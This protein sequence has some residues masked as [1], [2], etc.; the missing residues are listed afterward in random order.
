MSAM[1]REQGTCTGRGFADTDADGWCAK[2]KTWVQKPIASGG[3]GWHIILDKSAQPVEVAITAVDTGSNTITAP[4]HGLITG[5][6][7]QFFTTGTQMGGVTT[8]TT[9][10]ALVLSGDTLQVQNSLM[11]SAAIRTITSAGSNNTIRRAGP[12]IVVCE[13]ATPDLQDNKRVI[14]VGYRI[15]N[16]ALVDIQHFLSAGQY[17]T[18]GHPSGLWSGRTLKAVDAGPFTYDFRGGPEFLSLQTKVPGDAT[19]YSDTIDE[20]APLDGLCEDDSVVGGVVVGDV[21]YTAGNQSTPLVVTLQSAAQVDSFTVRQGYFIYRVN[22]SALNRSP[23][24]VAYGIINGK[25]VDDGLTAEQIRFSFVSG[26]NWSV[27]YIGNGARI[28]PYYHN[29]CCFGTRNASSAGDFMGSFNDFNG[30]S[31]GTDGGDAH[32][33]AIAKGKLPYYSYNGG[34]ESRVFHN[35]TGAV[36]GTANVRL[37]EIVYRVAQDN[38]LLPVQRPAIDEVFSPNGHASASMNRVYGELKNVFCSITAGLSRMEFGRTIGGINYIYYRT[39]LGLFGSV[40]AG[41]N[42]AAVLV[43]HSESDS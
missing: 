14:K 10:Y 16:A 30:N 26:T 12:Y 33:S 32:S 2:F 25:G 34:N 24:H 43:R 28:S 29:F 15:G 19:W 3:P 27:P 1:K 38:L 23:V 36:D 18:G 41:S 8:A 21:P 22:A 20:W 9:Y 40:T 11:Q 31:T 37:D 6:P 4:G 7:I 35:Q 42:D 17:L 5:E 13:S 39:V